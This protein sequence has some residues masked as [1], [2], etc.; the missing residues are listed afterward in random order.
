MPPLTTEVKLTD[1]PVDGEEGEKE[2]STVNGGITGEVIVILTVVGAVVALNGEPVTMK[3]Y[4]PGVTE[5]VTLI[6]KTLVAPAVVGV[7]GLTV[8]DPQVIP[9]GRLLLTQDNVTG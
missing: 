1:C 8:K 5:D 4:G 7:T 6:V 9:A 2:K 3:L